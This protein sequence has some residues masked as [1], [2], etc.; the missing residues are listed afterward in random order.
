MEKGLAVIEMKEKE[1]DRA[2]SIHLKDT[3]KEIALE[4]QQE[5]NKLL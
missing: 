5:G 2:R 1:E 4:V 3:E